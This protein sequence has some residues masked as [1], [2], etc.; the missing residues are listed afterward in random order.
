MTVKYATLSQVKAALRIT[1]QIDDSLLNTSIDAAS[2][3]VDGW[4]GRTFTK[5]SGTATKDYVPSGRMEPLFVNDLTTVVSI[6][7]DE[8]LDRTFTTLLNPIDFQLEPV[9]G[10]FGNGFPF[11]IIRPQEDGYW[12]TSY[13]R[14][15]VRV[16]ATYGWPAIPDAVREATILAGVTAVHAVGLAAGYRRV[17]GHGCDARL[18]QG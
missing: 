6:R 5:A 4:C 2:R 8:D 11:Y 18:V 13:G 14:A 7:I 3:W 17:R 9:N 1:D 10:S 16:Q 15:T 12:P